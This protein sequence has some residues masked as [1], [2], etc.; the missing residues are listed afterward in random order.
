MRRV[1]TAATIARTFAM[2]AA[3]TCAAAASP[4]QIPG[5]VPIREIGDGITLFHITD[6]ALIE[7]PAPLSVWLLRLDPAHVTLAAALANDEVMGT[8]TV[9][10]TAA[11]H[12]AVAA[13]NAGFFLPNGDPAGLFKLSGRL[14]SDT[15]RPRGAVG[16][17][18]SGKRM[19]LLF[20]RVTA[21]MALKIHA[22]AGRETTLPIDGI[23]T[24]RLRGK[25]MLFTPAYHDHTDTAPGGFEWAVTGDPPRVTGGPF[26]GGKTPIPDNGF[27]LS[28]GGRSPPPAL[29]ALRRGSQVTLVPRYVPESGDPRSWAAAEHII[30][31]AGLLIRDG[32][33]VD[34][35]TLEQFSP[36]FAE[37]RHPRTMVGITAEGFIWLVAV[38]G[39]R[40]HLSAGMTLPE[41]RS[42]AIRLALVDALNLDGGGSTT[43]WATGAVVN[44]PSDAAG[45]RKVSDALLVFPLP[46]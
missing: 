16:I 32:R 14:V 8:E 11:R 35:W 7:P 36:G 28:Y 20:D 2:A 38:D 30:G 27:V 9:A 43:M 31:G 22:R 17:A 6:P 19:R 45:P 5:L 23:D 46:H 4:T 13:I 40:A 10:D 12:Q 15:R 25:L 42:L 44:S 1:R 39:R 33:P 34:D 37:N 41:L 3:L 18:T 21:T 29:R 26:E 24:T